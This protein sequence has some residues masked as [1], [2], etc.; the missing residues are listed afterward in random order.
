MKYIDIKTFFIALTLGLFLNYITLKPQKVILV[1]PTQDN[2]NQIQMKDNSD[3][4][5]GLKSKEVLCPENK[6]DIMKIPYQK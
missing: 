4:C 5:F 3:T 2:Y 1:Y 6:S